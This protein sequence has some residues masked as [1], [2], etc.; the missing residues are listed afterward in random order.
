MLAERCRLVAA[1]PPCEAWLV[2]ASCAHFATFFHHL[3]G[4]SKDGEGII[5]LIKAQREFANLELNIR[6]IGKV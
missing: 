4:S 3:K 5:A 6:V 2:A 1:E